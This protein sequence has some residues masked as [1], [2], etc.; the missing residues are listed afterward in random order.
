[1]RPA[2]E[3]W[4]FKEHSW[5][6]T[7]DL[8]HKESPELRPG[9]ADSPGKGQKSKAARIRPLAVVVLAKG[10]TQCCWPRAALRLGVS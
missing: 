4:D 2:V 6:L 7:G 3:S 10:R 8:L 9:W 5:E 1:M